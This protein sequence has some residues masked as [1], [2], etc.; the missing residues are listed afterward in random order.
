MGERPKGS[1]SNVEILLRRQIPRSAGIYINGQ[2][3]DIDL[4][5]T[6]DTG[7]RSYYVSKSNFR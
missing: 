5:Y 3:G 2:I 7:D 4:V 1:N 6:V